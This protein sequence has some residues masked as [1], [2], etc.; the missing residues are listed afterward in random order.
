MRVLEP[1][2]VGPVTVRSRP[3]PTQSSTAR[4]DS[5]VYNDVLQLQRLAGNR[6]VASLLR[7]Q[8]DQN[9]ETDNTA[10]T[11]VGGP[12]PEQ[13]ARTEDYLT[14]AEEAEWLEASGIPVQRLST[15]AIS[16]NP[17]AVTVQ[18]WYNA[19][20][21]L[22]PL[23]LLGKPWV[24]RKSGNLVN[25]RLYH[26]HL[27]F[28]DGRG[29]NASRHPWEWDN[30]GHMGS[31]GL[32]TDDPRNGYSTVRQGNAAEDSLM[33]HAVDRVVSTH[34]A[35]PGRYGLFSN[36]CQDFVQ[37]VLAQFDAMRG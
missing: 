35:D 22:K 14:P 36:N 1:K 21:Q 34:I 10:A 11:T 23:K 19:R 8:R 30:V 29:N 37:S 24:V 32:G 9:A 26:E 12:T 15:G 33:R 25:M 27:F 6:A 28:T 17:A 18:R 4:Q 31:Q 7:A 3:A 13:G 16:P 2:L 5:S 20:R